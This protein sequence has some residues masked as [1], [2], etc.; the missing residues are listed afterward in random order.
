[1]LTNHQQDTHFFTEHSINI[2]T[3]MLQ[4]FPRTHQY[5]H[6]CTK[7][8]F[9]RAEFRHSFDNPLQRQ[10]DS[11]KANF[12]FYSTSSVRTV[13]LRGQK[14]HTI[15]RWL[16]APAG[17]QFSVYCKHSGSNGLDLFLKLHSQLQPFQ[18]DWIL[19]ELAKC[20]A[21]LGRNA[22]LTKWQHYALV[23]YMRFRV[24]KTI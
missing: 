2:T 5:L 4:E 21:P 22:K 12:V 15:Y 24:H 9:A 20:N 11:K 16:H 13:S 17:S 1:M 19:W 18:K 23:D 8:G 3:Q 6:R 10:Q 7:P 14:I